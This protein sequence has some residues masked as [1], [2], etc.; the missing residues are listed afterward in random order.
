MWCR[1]VWPGGISEPR[2]PMDVI[3]SRS[4]GT[5]E[6]RVP[7]GQDVLVLSV[8]EP[9]EPGVLSLSPQPVKR[10]TVT[11]VINRMPAKIHLYLLLPFFILY[12]L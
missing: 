6:N 5:L 2:T 10:K 4:M 9:E 12:F 3:S 11:E 7:V 1:K 8:P